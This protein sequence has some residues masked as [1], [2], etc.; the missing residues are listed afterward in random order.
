MEVFSPVL[1]IS[2]GLAE[3]CRAK[4]SSPRVGSARPPYLYDVRGGPRIELGFRPAFSGVDHKTAFGE[5]GY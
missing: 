2:K 3:V 1:P 4:K 5:T